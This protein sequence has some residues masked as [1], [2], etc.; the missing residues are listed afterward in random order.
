LSALL[1]TSV[2]EKSSVRRV[3][4]RASREKQAAPFRRLARRF[5][6]AGI[7]VTEKW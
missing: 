2:P 7:G 5:G 4:R 1:S 6:A 3:C